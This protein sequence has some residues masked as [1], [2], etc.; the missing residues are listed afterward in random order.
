MGVKPLYYFEDKG[1]LIFGSELKSLMVHPGFKKALSKH[2]LSLFLYHGYITAPHTIFENTYKLKPGTYLHFKDGKTVIKTYWSLEEKFKKRKILDLPEEEWV[3][4]L[5]GLL[6]GSVKDRMIS[7]VPIGCFLSGGIDSSLIA[8]MMQ[9]VST[10][11]VKTFTIGFHSS[12]YDEAP[13]AKQVAQKLGT[14]HSEVYLSQDEAKNIIP[15][16]PYHY[17]EPFADSS[18]IP[19][20][21]L[22]KITRKKVTVALSGDGGDELFCGYGRY[23]D[24]MR[25][26]KLSTA[27]R[28]GSAIPFFKGLIS[29][30]TENS[31]YTQFF[32][33]GNEH[34]IINSSY[35]N[36]LKNSSFIKNHIS[37]FD[38][39]YNDIMLATDNFQE[40]HM[41]QDMITYL[42]DDILTKVDRASMAFSLEAR[43]PF[44]DD[45]RLVEFSFQLPHAMKYKNNQK[46]YI[47]K[48]LLY[49]HLPQKLMDRPKMGF[50]VPI[51]D[52]LRGDLRYLVDEYLSSSYL[53]KQNIFNEKE[54][55]RLKERFFK[56]NDSL[57]SS[58]G[59]IS[60][61]KLNKDGFV[62]RSIWHLLI[63]QMWYKQYL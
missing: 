19:M 41:L 7:D 37:S 50:G 61:Y 51:Y 5:E 34:S 1:G 26:K 12:N 25:L 22:S 44:I 39:A 58:N 62:D 8:T 3:E 31:K 28:I 6:K 43:T 47:L 52:W 60:K 21:L 18:Q 29:S 54:V 23:E 9:K 2:S 49:K 27:S 56:N 42:P 35:L 15:E 4:N 33:L 38:A 55:L 63:F 46:K 40:K 57:K 17:D 13:Y 59:L 10:A 30:F 53:K 32:E 48:K 16:I 14:D 11:P 20:M 24:I 36:Y 45:H